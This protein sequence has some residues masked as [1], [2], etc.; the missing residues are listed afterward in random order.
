MR[1]KVSES[2]TAAAAGGGG[3]ALSLS[4][5][6]SAT[7]AVGIPKARSPSAAAAAVARGMSTSPRMGPTGYGA[8][9]SLSASF[10]AAAEAL[11]LSSSMT[12][13]AAQPRSFSAGFKQERSLGHQHFGRECYGPGSDAMSPPSAGL[14]MLSSSAGGLLDGSHLENE[15][16]GLHARR[17]S[18]SSNATEDDDA[19]A[20]RNGM[21]GKFVGGTP[22]SHQNSQQLLHKCES[23]AKVYRHP[24]CLVKHRWVS[25]PVI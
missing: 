4:R 9:G 16:A 21:N 12:S 10:G 23:C 5:Q 22:L 17:S 13:T 8:D 15:K 24:S 25:V 14:S 6:S 18:I 11:S 1:R 20:G 19:G 2:T 3:S 7:G